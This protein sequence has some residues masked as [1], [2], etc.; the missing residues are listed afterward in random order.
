[1][2]GQEYHNVVITRV[3]ADK[4]YILHEDGAASLNQADLPPDLQK[5][6]NY[7][8]Q[9]AAAAAQHRASERA[10]L[11]AEQQQELVAAAQQSSAAQAAQDALDSRKA[12]RAQKIG[13]LTA[14]INKAQAAIAAARKEYFEMRLEIYEQSPPPSRVAELVAIMAQ[15]HDIFDSNGVTQQQLTEDQ[16]TLARLQLTPDTP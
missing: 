15:D 4:V 14:R 16:R 9:L 2:N 12:Q 11:D 1:M 3:E 6:C 13:I 8:P 5:L 10:R 7:N